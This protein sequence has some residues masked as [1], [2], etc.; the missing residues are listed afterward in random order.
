MIILLW[1]G[2]LVLAVALSGSLALASFSVAER[3]RQIGVDGR[4]GRARRRSSATSCSRTWSSRIR[5]AAG[6]SLTFG[7]NLVIAS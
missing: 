7:L 5:A 4:W 3:S 1:T 2:F 6:D